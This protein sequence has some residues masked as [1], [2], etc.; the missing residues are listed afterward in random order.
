MSLF[1]FRPKQVSKNLLGV[2]PERTYDIIV[3]RF[4]LGDSPER[5]TLEFIGNRYGVTRERVRQ[6]EN[7]G[8]QAIKNSDVYK[9]EEGAFKELFKV[10]DTLG[11]VVPEDHLLELLA[12]DP[13]TQNHIYFYLV[14]GDEFTRE[15]E[16]DDLNHHWT[17]D[18][19]LA[20]KIHIILKK[21]HANLTDEDLIPESDM[22]ASFLTHAKDIPEKYRNDE[23]VKRWLKLSRHIDRNDFGDWGKASSSNIRT[24]GMRDY[25]YLI[26]RRHGSPMH[27]REVAQNITKAFG[28]S[29]HVATCHNELIKD[30]R[31]IL[32]GRGLYALSDWGY[33]KGVVRD[34][35]REILKKDG[36]LS[37]EAI[38]ER[39]LKER[40]VKENTILVNLQNSKYFKKVKGGLYSNA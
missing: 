19:V 25:A 10:V 27:F 18:K 33:T 6:V 4:G 5:Q 7:S 20:H 11:A 1:S 26:I 14:L 37:K 39:V 9:K 22:I 21:V 16:S 36:P 32:V 13:V 34:V 31:F 15:K 29:A 8:L 38:T 2:L 24:R 12:S 3:S 35:I 30:P 40:Y 23:V 28:K 17:I